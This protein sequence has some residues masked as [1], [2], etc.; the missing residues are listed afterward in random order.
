[1]YFSNVSN[2][3]LLPAFSPEAGTMPSMHQSH[4]K[5]LLNPRTNAIHCIKNGKELTQGKHMPNMR[6]FTNELSNTR[7]NAGPHIRR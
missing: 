3:V 6:E 2:F 4:S 5:H 7:R 1:M